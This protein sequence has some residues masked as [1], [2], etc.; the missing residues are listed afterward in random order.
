MAD[1]AIWNGS[2]SFNQ[3]SSSWYVTG[4]GPRP[5][6]FGFYD[7]DSQFKTD[8]DKVADFCARRLGYPIVNVEL[9]D[10]QFWTAFE[11]AV[12]TY[13]NELY[14]FRIRDNYLSLEGSST[15]SALNNSLITPN[16]STV[17]RISKQYGSEAGVGGTMTYYTG[18]VVLT[19]SVQDY[20]LSEWAVSNSIS[21]SDLEI[22]KIF[23]EG[24]PAVN[25]FFDPYAGTG[26]GMMNLMSSFGWGGYSPAITFMLMPISFD[27]QIIQSI[28]FNDQIR[29]S[30][31]SFQLINNRLRIFPI[32]GDNETGIR[33]WFQ[34]ALSS[35]RYSGS[36]SSQP[37]NITNVSN[38]PYT[39]PVYSQINSIGRSWIFEYTLAVVKEILGLSV[40]G[41][42]NTIPIPNDNTSLNFDQLINSAKEE[43]IALIEN[44][45]KYFDETSR[46]SLLERQ[47]KE[48]EFIRTELTNIPNVIYI[49]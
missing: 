27:T 19:S 15:A 11:E 3:V 40:R 30:S 28:K 18:S 20:N 1:I 31:F 33:L 36:I 43:K 38:V 17:I 22:K 2:S 34:Y 29:K 6:P 41:K 5:T 10:I 9:Q 32:P 12:T 47:S 46:Q 24:S 14:A 45:R 37:S 48:R 21:A 26:M 35:D 13:G 16:L 44:L 42:Y 25:R 23:Y 4:S 39:N 8:A 7:T 49:G